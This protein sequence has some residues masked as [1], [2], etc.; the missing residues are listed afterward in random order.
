[1]KR[2][3]RSVTALLV[4]ALAVGVAAE[5]T[6]VSA[7]DYPSFSCAVGSGHLS[8]PTPSKSVAQGQSAVYT[9]DI[10]RIG[11]PDA[12]TLSAADYLPPGGTATF[13]ENPTTADSVTLTITTSNSWSSL[14]PVGG[15][16]AHIYVSTGYNFP[17]TIHLGL[18]LTVT[19]S[20]AP[21]AKTPTSALTG[22]TITSTTAKVKI[23]WGAVDPDG[24]KSYTV[25]RQVNGG[26]WT[27]V[28]LSSPTQT[29]I[30][31]SHTFNATYRYRL[32]ATDRLGHR[33]SIAYGR[34]F[35]ITLVQ[36]TTRAV[37]SPWSWTTQS[38]S[39]ASGGSL[40]YQPYSGSDFTYTFSAAS[41]AWVSVTGPTRS[42]SVEIL[43][44]GVSVRSNLSLRASATTY[45]KIVF[46]KNFGSNARR[47]L[48]VLNLGQ[49]G[50][51]R[52][53]IDAFVLLSFS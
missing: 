9:I 22:G 42:N 49:T 7:A 2:V 3:I 46:A 35:K 4:I 15:Y 13:S 47:S 51:S 53:D 32:S 16:G 12:I 10:E 11:C 23:G 1:M 25:Q 44:D 33:G 28:A 38:T 52:L 27:T 39:S 31:S 19:A 50:H 26:A 36:Q 5:A 43:V 8:T 45:R 29:S 37:S 20:I 48:Y 41:V 34:P 21:I 14:T 40:K 24:I 17:G 30:T 18:D 6:P